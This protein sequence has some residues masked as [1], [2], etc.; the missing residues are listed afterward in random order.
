[1]SSLK[2][3]E[4]VGFAAEFHLTKLTNICSAPTAFLSRNRPFSPADTLTS[5]VIFVRWN[6]RLFSAVWGKRTVNQFADAMPRQVEQSQ[7]G[8]L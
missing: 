2:N 3:R 6:F 1:M 5:K 4:A 7:H 8:N